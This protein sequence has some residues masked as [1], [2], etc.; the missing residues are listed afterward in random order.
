MHKQRYLDKDDSS[1]LRHP[2]GYVPFYVLK[3]LNDFQPVDKYLLIAICHLTWLS[4]RKYG[5]VWYH[6][7]SSKLWYL[8]A[9]SFV[10]FRK[11]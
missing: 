10:N 4:S 2:F 6:P 1:C 9:L 11:N 7:A 5:T 3:L 8:I